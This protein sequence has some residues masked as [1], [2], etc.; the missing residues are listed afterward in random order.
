MTERLDDIVGEM[1]EWGPRGRVAIDTKVLLDYADRILAAAALE[2]AEH[3]RQLEEA[4]APL[5]ENEGR[6][7]DLSPTAKLNAAGVGSFNRLIASRRAKYIKPKEPTSVGAS[8]E[9]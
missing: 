6:R 7:P 5:T 8:D 2:R 9:Q 3:R 1:R 4:L